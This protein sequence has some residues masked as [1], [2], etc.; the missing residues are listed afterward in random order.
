[1]SWLYSFGFDGSFSSIRLIWFFFFCSPLVNSFDPLPGNYHFTLSWSLGHS[2]KLIF[3]IWYLGICFQVQVETR[4]AWNWSIFLEHDCTNVW[5]ISTKSIKC[6]ST[7]SL[8]A[9]N[10][11]LYITFFAMHLHIYTSN[12]H[13]YGLRKTRPMYISKFN[14]M[15]T[16]AECKKPLQYK[17]HH[18][19]AYQGCNSSNSVTYVDSVRCHQW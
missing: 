16:R 7:I 11:K 13:V 17:E 12:V 3:I 9:A 14:Y 2:L 4:N 5:S 8:S 10:I 1:M 18:R 6:T 19:Y 15:T